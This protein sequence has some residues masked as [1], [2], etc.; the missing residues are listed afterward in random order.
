MQ[1]RKA[2]SHDFLGLRHLTVREDASVGSLIGSLGISRGANQLLRYTVTNGEESSHF[3]TDAANG[4]IYTAKPLDYETNQQYCFEVHPNVNTTILVAVSVDDVNDHTPSFP[5]NN[6]IVVFGVQEDVPVGTVVYVFKAVDGDAT[7]HNS[8]IRYTMTFDPTLATEKL[9]FRIDP[10]SG[11]VLTTLPLD[12]ERNQSFAFIVTASDGSHVNSV[13]AQVFLLDVNDNS[14]AFVSKETVHVAEDTEVGSLLHHFLA[15]DE[16]E[17]VNSHVTFSL[18]SGNEAGVFRLE[19][20]GK[21]LWCGT[22]Y[23]VTEYYSQRRMFTF[24]HIPVHIVVF[25]N[26]LRLCPKSYPYSLFRTNA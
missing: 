22:C 23:K 26:R 6:N 19:N 18:I 21:L 17:G 5:G 20:S 12:R 10:D 9:S 14:P 15:R 11:V 4:N 16:D 24:A 1:G 8:A 25:I 2:G 3:T 13:T 7:L